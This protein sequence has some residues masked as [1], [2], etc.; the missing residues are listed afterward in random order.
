[1][2]AIGGRGLRAGL[3]VQAQQPRP[4]RGKLEPGSQGNGAPY[5]ALAA[6]YALGAAGVSPIRAQLRVSI[7]WWIM[8]L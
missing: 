3:R 4:I 5:F 1:M 6:R 8:R 2:Q 7:A